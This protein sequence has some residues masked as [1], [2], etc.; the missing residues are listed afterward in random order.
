MNSHKT[1]K[2]AKVFSLESFLLCSTTCIYTTLS[3][4]LLVGCYSWS[5]V[6]SIPTRIIDINYHFD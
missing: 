2:F 4:I 1:A 5:S 6:S 3:G